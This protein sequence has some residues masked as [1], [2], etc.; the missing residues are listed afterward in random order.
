MNDEYYELGILKETK[1]I[2]IG[3]MKNRS[4]SWVLKEEEQFIHLLK[5]SKDIFTWCKTE[6]EGID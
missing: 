4:L 1:M 5:R 6:M 2:S 3:A